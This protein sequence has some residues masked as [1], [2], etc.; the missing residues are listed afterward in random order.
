MNL[1]EKF[2]R[3]IK[4]L[5]N[6]L[7]EDEKPE[8]KEE[9]KVLPTISVDPA[10]GVSIEEPSETEDPEEEPISIEVLAEQIAVMQGQITKL[11]IDVETLKGEQDASKK[12]FE[13]QF[14]KISKI[15]DKIVKLIKK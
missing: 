14:E 6:S 12:S 13:G 5:V 1:K 10:T 7:F 9:E 3:G 15:L 8:V 4:D 2:E 11:I